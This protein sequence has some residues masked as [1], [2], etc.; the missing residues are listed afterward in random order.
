[1][2]SRTLQ[3]SE[4]ANKLTREDVSAI[5]VMYGNESRQGKKLKIAFAHAIELGVF[6]EIEADELQTLL[7]YR[8][9][10]AHRIHLVMADISRSYWNTDHLSLSAPTYKGDALERL[11]S[12]RKS[13]W[14]RAKGLVIMLSMDSVMF[15]FA[16]S[17]YESGAQTTRPAHPEAN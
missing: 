16:E 5:R 14:Q 12:Y 2:F 9:D 10:I 6:T 13:L 8:N 11:R 3:D 17:V 15:E 1:M 4:L 7:N